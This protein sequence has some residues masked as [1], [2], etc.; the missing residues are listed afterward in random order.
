MNQRMLVHL[1]L[2]PLEKGAFFTIRKTSAPIYFPLSPLIYRE[3][4]Y[5][6]V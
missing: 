3:M 2:C 4:L 6:D 1:F 5:N